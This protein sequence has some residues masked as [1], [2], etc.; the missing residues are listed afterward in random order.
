MSI[1]H[2]LKVITPNFKKEKFYCD[3]CN[4]PLLTNEDFDHEN[5]WG[6]CHDCFVKFAESR[7]EEWKKGWRPEK[8]VLRDYILIKNKLNQ[9]R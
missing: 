1:T 8:T 4:Y 6:C 2:R 3:L 5:D 9:R 7:K